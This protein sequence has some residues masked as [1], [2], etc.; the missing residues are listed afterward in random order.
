MVD[1][2]VEAPNI[3]SSTVSMTEQVKVQK[4]TDLVLGSVLR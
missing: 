1:E 4:P 3:V 2:I